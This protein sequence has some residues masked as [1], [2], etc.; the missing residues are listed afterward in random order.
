M[1]GIVPYFFICGFFD[2]FKSNSRDDSRIFWITIKKKRLFA[3]WIFSAHF[4]RNK[5]L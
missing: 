5:I 2:Q 1:F 4:D 3:N